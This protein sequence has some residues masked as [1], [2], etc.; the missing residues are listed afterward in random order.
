MN[1]K[2][3]APF[4]YDEVAYPTPINSMQT[5]ERLGASI[6]LHGLSAPDP[7]TARVLEIGCGNGYSLIGVAANAPGC[8]CVGFDL[9]AKAVAVGHELVAKAELENVE[10]AHGDILTWPRDGEPYD[11]ILCHGVY[12]W[13]PGVVRDSLMELCGKLLAPGGLCYIGYDCLPGAAVKAALNRF[14]IANVSD[15]PDISARVDAAVALVAVLARHQREGSRLKA[16][17]DSLLEDAPTYVRAYFFHD[18]L[19]EYYHPE[20]IDDFVA[21]AGREGLAYVGDAA[22]HDLMIHDLDRDGRALLARQGDDPAL[23]N[24]ALDMLRGSHMFRGDMLTRLDKPAPHLEHPLRELSF[25]FVGS[26]EEVTLEGKPAVRFAKGHDK[27]FLTLAEGDQRELMELLWDID[28]EEISF[29][30]LAERLGYTAERL[31]AA[32]RKPVVMGLVETHC[33]PQNFTLRPGERPKAGQLIRAMMQMGDTA[34]TLRHQKFVAKE[35]P[36]RLMLALCDGTRTRADIAG[37]MSEAYGATV[38]VGQVEQAI[39]KFA[40]HALFEG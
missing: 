33:T 7:R 40:P 4:A 19:A 21:G 12:S 29:S 22:L 6:M 1:Q 34:I 5:P 9:S 31:E 36:T 23:L 39:V 32:M 35:D 20:Y 28:P 2:A 17:I 37:S 26:R 24:I 13:V 15:I 16:Q 8:R 27:V 30:G 11:Y 14:L 18:W 38:P 25:A 10:L 3:A